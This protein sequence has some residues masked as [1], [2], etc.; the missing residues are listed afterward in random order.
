MPLNRTPRCHTT[1]GPLD[2]PIQT[3]APPTRAITRSV[4]FGPSMLW[5][6]PTNTSEGIGIVEEHVL[7]INIKYMYDWIFLQGAV[8][9]ESLLFHVHPKFY[10]ISLVILHS[11][12]NSPPQKCTY[13]VFFN[14]NTKL[15]SHKKVILQPIKLIIFNIKLL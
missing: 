13:I 14:Q 1:I 11:K 6:L 5:K 7:N 4:I 10:M 8:Y 15:C 12:L 3:C 9:W 2:R